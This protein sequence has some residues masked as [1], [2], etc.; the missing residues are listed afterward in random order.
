[1]TAVPIDS[2]WIL[3]SGGSTEAHGYGVL[4]DSF[5]LNGEGRKVSVPEM[6]VARW[7]ACSAIIGSNQGS[8][9]IGILGGNGPGGA[10]RSMERYECSKDEVPECIKL[11]NGPENIQGRFV[12]GCGSLQTSQVSALGFHAK[13]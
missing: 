3:F 2:Q 6:S 1:M 8:T 5:L 13:K 10:Q 12:F 7:G 11:P 4:K 9:Q